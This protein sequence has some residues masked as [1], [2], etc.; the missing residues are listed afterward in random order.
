M[1]VGNPKVGCYV[2]YEYNHSVYLDDLD[3]P[4]QSLLRAALEAGKVPP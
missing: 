2:G 1:A 3:E 4:F